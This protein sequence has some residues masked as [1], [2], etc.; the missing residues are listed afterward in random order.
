MTSITLAIF[1]SNYWAIIISGFISQFVKVVLSYICF[2]GSAHRWRLSTARAVDLWR[3]SRFI[4]GSTILTLAISQFDKIVIA[5]LFP[6]NILGLYVIAS[7][8]A[9]VPRSLADAYATRV[10]FPAYSETNRLR[11]QELRHV[12]Y[13]QKRNLSYLY[14]FSIGGLISCSPLVVKIL[15]T[16][17]YGLVAVYMQIMLVATLF[18]MSNSA[19]NDVMIARGESWFTLSANLVRVAFIALI[20]P[21]AYFIG[22]VTGIIWTVG[23]LELAV[24]ID[25]WTILGKRKI[26]DVRSEGALLLAA[27]L[28]ALI[29]F[30]INRESVILLSGSFV[31]G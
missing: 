11:P 12:F 19:T 22:G 1:Y 29:G 15:Y 13:A 17:Q 10:L 28:G 30:I 25:G 5:K 24:Q 14:N 31:N 18:A 8:V 21:G 6:L 2:S 26:L 20:G 27:A 9:A 16:R 23:T 3:F 4:T 7:S